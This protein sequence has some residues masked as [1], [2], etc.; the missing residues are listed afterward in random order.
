M[1][2]SEKYLESRARNAAKAR[3]KPHRRGDRAMRNAELGVWWAPERA[4]RV[5]TTY[6]EGDRPPRF[7]ME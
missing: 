3:A 5:P 2:F 4:P 6:V 1:S 7:T